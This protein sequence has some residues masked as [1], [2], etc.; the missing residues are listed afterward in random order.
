MRQRK[1]LFPLLLWSGLI[2]A[3]TLTWVW[4]GESNLTMILAIVST[5]AALA[6]LLPVGPLSGFTPGR[7]STPEQVDQAAELLIMEVRRQWD[8]EARR[9]R[10]QEARQMPVRWRI[11]RQAATPRSS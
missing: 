11:D 4:L 8:E 9:R 6:P 3:V 2:L 1:V 10:L 7:P 5:F